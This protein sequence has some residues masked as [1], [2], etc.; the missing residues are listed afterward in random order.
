[1]SKSSDLGWSHFGIT[2]AYSINTLW[3]QNKAKRVKVIYIWKPQNICTNSVWIFRWQIP[4]KFKINICLKNLLLFFFML[5]QWRLLRNVSQIASFDNFQ[6]Q[7][8]IWFE[9][10]TLICDL[11]LESS[12]EEKIRRIWKECQRWIYLSLKIISEADISFFEKNLRS[13][14][15]FL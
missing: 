10:S 11:I 2:S 5:G 12:R 7:S 14:N 1:M 4:L 15:I 8:G 9:S 3:R 13:E 6:E